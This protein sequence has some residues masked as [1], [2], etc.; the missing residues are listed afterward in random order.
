MTID[1]MGC[2]KEIAETIMDNSGNYVLQLKGNRGGLHAETVT[3]FDECLRDDCLGIEHTT[4][5]TINKGRGRI[6]WRT[7]CATEDV[8]W[9]AERDK[10]KGLRRLVRVR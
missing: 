5:R 1:A 2:P 7:I 3:L 8:R 9:F 10:W 4:A 6:E